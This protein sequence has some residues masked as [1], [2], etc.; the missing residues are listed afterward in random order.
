MA[1]LNPAWPL[2]RG[3]VVRAYW[4]APA[5]LLD[6]FDY[7]ERYVGP[8]LGWSVDLPAIVPP[9]AFVA[10]LFL[11]AVLS[12]RD[13]LSKAGKPDVVFEV[14][15]SIFSLSNY[16]HNR[17]KQPLDMAAVTLTGQLRNRAD[18]KADIEGVSVALMERG[19]LWRWTVVGAERAATMLLGPSKAAIDLYRPGVSVDA[20]SRSREISEIWVYIPIPVSLQA[21]T[22]RAYRLRIFVDAYGQSHPSPMYQSVDVPSAFRIGLARPRY[23]GKSKELTQNTE[24]SSA[25]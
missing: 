24:G 9:I 21:G 6:P 8:N 10:G 12:Y 23:L 7:I 1:L 18:V 2:L 5:I 19:W 25:Q 16:N 3:I 22:K 14:R 11:A 20:K 15:E 13:V 17:P 4:M